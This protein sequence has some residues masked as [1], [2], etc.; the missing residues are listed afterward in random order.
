MSLEPFSHTYAQNICHFI[1]C[2]K[3]RYNMFRKTR[4]KNACIAAIR[5]AAYR[6]KLK[7]HEITVDTDHVH[8]IVA[9]PLTMTISKAFQLLKGLS[10]YLLFNAFPKL[11]FR[12]PR[13]HLWSIGKIC[14]SIGDADLPTVRE[15]ITKH[16]GSQA[17]LLNFA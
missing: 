6:H 9:V 8:S 2:T 5:Q 3:Y 4:Y 12:Y 14:R 1:W 13:G 16:K 7:I 17:L 10:A 15:Y 11:R